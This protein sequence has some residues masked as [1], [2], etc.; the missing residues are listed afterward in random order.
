MS[1]VRTEGNSLRRA[2]NASNLRKS[3]VASEKD[4][5]DDE[6]MRVLKVLG[7]STLLAFFGLVVYLWYL[8]RQNV[9]DYSDEMYTR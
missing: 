4:C 5:E 9:R 7:G 8:L 6:M 2:V 1:R 3:N